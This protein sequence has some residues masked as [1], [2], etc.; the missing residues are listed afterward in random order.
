MAKLKGQ[1]RS[2][3]IAGPNGAG[4]TTFAR[5]D[6]PDEARVVNFAYLAAAGGWLSGARH[7]GAR[8]PTIGGNRKIVKPL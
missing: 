4:K 1:P 6:L 2:I 3:V 8:A 5:R 7:L